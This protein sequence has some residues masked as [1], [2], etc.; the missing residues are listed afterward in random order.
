MG[1]IAFCH[2]VPEMPSG[3]SRLSTREVAT[4]WD[5]VYLRMPSAPCRRP[6]PEA[7]MPPIGAAVLPNARA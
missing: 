7:F 4:V 6:T 5:S 3:G 1:V 2:S